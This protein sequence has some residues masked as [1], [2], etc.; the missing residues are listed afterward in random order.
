MSNYFQVLK[1]IEQDRSN[2][3]MAAEGA[4]AQRDRSEEDAASS[5]DAA[6]VVGPAAAAPPVAA[7]PVNTVQP[8]AH[9]TH[10]AAPTLNT[11]PPAAHAKPAPPVAATPAAPAT[12]A[13]ATAPSS[14]VTTRPLRAVHSAPATPHPAPTAPSDASAP[15]AP[16]ELK[17]P[18][19]RPAAS[20][21]AEGQRGIATL[22]DNIRALAS[23]RATR[24]LVF[25]GAA[26]TDSV[27][28]VTEGLARHAQRHGMRVFVAELTRT[29][30][31]AM[32]VS[33]MPSPPQPLTI[34]LDG[35]AAPGELNA[36]V[37]DAAGDSDLVVLEAPPLADSIDAALL[38]CAC[39]GLV[40]VADTEVTPRGALHIA[41]E[42]A[43]IAGCRTLG[44]VMN[45]TRER[46]P[47]WMRRLF[48]TD[49]DA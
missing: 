38:A 13:P 12:V 26:A 4:A 35:G 29:G 20:L 17:P 9:A 32:L 43:Q 2:R 3:A 1:R 31:G 40:I 30:G 37:N 39:D 48:G 6:A 14:S 46:L 8:A 27:W 42:R 41:A 5:S 11:A 16:I 34:G 19:R 21:S 33:R 49:G 36:W 28:A 15:A 45:G 18:V 22:F 25:A 24:A 7:P 10:T 44:V 47:I 23:G